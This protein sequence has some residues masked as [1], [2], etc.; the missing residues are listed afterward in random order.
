MLPVGLIIVGTL[1]GLGAPPPAGQI[2]AAAW[3][4]LWIIWTWLKV[5]AVN[6]TES[7]G[8]RQEEAQ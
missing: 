3:I 4:A 5:W 6:K 1:L 7:H 8:A 2:F